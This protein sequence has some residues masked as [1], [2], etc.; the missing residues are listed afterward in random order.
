MA[1]DEI[2]PEVMDVLV[3]ADWFPAYDDP[4]AGR[5]VADQV[6]A[7]AATGLVAPR[8]VSFDAALLTGG[9]AARRQ[10]EAAVLTAARTLAADSR[11]G[12]LPTS[13]V[14]DGVTVARLTV[15]EGRTSTT[16]AIHG[17]AHRADVLAAFVEARATP[18]AR[19]P[20]VVHAH[21]VYPT[22]A[23][24]ATLAD[25]LGWPLIVTEHSSFVDRIVADEAIRA[26][27]AAT[28]A[29][30]HRVIAVSS[31]LG[32]ELAEA[33]PAAAGH[34][35]VLPNAVPIE[36]FSLG[37]PAKRIPDQL[38]FVGH[39]KPTKGIE[40]LL[41]AVVVAR[42]Q[43]SAITLRLIGRSPDAATEAGWH[44]LAADLG[45]ADVVAFE[46]AV[47]R[48]AIAS[49][50]H[51]ASLF[52]HPSPRETFG[53]VAVEA[54]ATGLPVVAADSGGVTEIM[55][56][57]PRAVGAVVPAGDPAALGAAIVETLG[58][59]DGFDPAALR[60]SVERRFGGR[61]VA[62]RLA[63]V[64]REA[65]AA[66]PR[67]HGLVLESPAAP[68]L[69]ARAQTLVVA[70]DRARAASRLAAVPDDLRSSL[71]LVTAVEP[72]GVAIPPVGRRIELAVDA[73]WAPDRAAPARTRRAGWPGRLARLAHDPGATLRRVLR[74]DAG[75]RRSLAGTSDALVRLA[76]ELG[77]ER[78]VEVIALDGHDHLAIADALRTGS[79]R[80]G[81]GGLRRLV[82]E[83]GAAQRRRDSYP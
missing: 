61:Y 12:F 51:E 71:T 16:G 23:A 21:V 26:R 7:V 77:G 62:E 76:R 50:M 66:M 29:R 27:Y 5:F 78:P 11:T 35:E 53:V 75:T 38:L 46:E 49:A 41:R 32:R 6:E 64:Y 15:A 24:A 58:R 65:A 63:V 14:R 39:R 52:V 70:L 37:E 34:I 72:S 31:M 42:E 28:L 56:D 60:G 79:A 25:R 20:G 13:G 33:F 48:A 83:R 8:V 2:E 59:L 74:R 18:A 73:R 43:R 44:R 3:V 30:A 36:D 67:G 68:G 9:A 47:D 4:A 57:D 45:L 54:L 80:L 82:D 1:E 55:G 19:R 40:A 22:G 69:P 81:P 17:S 10:Q